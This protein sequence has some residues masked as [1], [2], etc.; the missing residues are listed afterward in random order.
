MIVTYQKLASLSFV[1]PW[2]LVN[3]S[4]L[5]LGIEFGYVVIPLSLVEVSSNWG[6]Q[7]V[8]GHKVRG[9]GVVPPRCRQ[10]LPGFITC[11]VTRL[12]VD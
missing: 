6:P 10:P 11:E 9:L 1:K 5:E 2:P 4:S 8:L 7:V 3:E 12:F